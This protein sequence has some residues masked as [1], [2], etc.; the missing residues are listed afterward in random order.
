MPALLA[1]VLADDRG[2]VELVDHIEDE[3]RELVLRQPLERRR[4]QQERLPR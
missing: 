3:V 2:E 4:W 1:L